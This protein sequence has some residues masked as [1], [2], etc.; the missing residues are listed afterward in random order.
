MLLKT[1]DAV[2]LLRS[3]IVLLLMGSS[4]GCHSAQAQ[5][6]VRS[7]DAGVRALSPDAAARVPDASGSPS[8]TCRADVDCVWNNPCFPTA[9]VPYVSVPH[10]IACTESAPAPGRCVCLNSTCAIAPIA[11]PPQ[12]VRCRSWRDCSWDPQRRVVVSSSVRPRRFNH[13]V[14]PCHDAEFDV[15]CMQGVCRMT[16]WGC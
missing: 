12:E 1:N 5:T 4:F 11:P 7:N 3:L 14:R 10:D 15:R 2:G 13:P 9:C 6:P 16:R 8:A